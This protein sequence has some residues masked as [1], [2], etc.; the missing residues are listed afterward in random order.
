MLRPFPITNFKA[1]RL[2]IEPD[3]AGAQ[4]AIDMLN[5]ELDRPGAVRSRDGYAKLTTS[6][7]ATR[8]DSVAAVAVGTSTA[9]SLKSAGTGADDATVGSAA[10]TNPGNITSSDNAYATFT[11]AQSHYLKATNFGF[12][13]PASATITGILVEVETS[14]D[15]GTQAFLVSMKLV[16]GGVIQNAQDKQPDVWNNTTDAYRSYGGSSDTW[17]N[18]WTQTDINASTFGVVLSVSMLPF[19]GTV[20]VDHVRITVYYTAANTTYVVAGATAGRLDAINSDGTVAATVATAAD[21]QASYANVGSPSASATYIGVGSGST[22]RKFVAPTTFSTPAGMPKARFVALQSPDNRLVA[23]NINA[24]P[25]GAGSTASTS[26]VHFS[27][28]GAPETW[29]ANNFVYVSPGDGEDIQGICAWRELVIVWKSTKFFVFFGNATDGSGNPIFQYRSITGIGAALASPLGVAPSPN[30]VYFIDRRGIYL[31]TGQ[32][33]TRISNHVDPL[34]IGGASSFY[35]GGII[36]PT[37]LSQCSLCWFSG[38]LYMGFPSGSATTN[39][40]TLVLNPEN[41][42]WMLWDMPMGAICSVGSQPANLVFTYSQ[43]TFDLGQY[44]QNAYSTDAGAAINWRY[45]SGFY[46]AGNAPSQETTI[47][48]T[49]ADGVGSPTLSVSRDFGAVPSVGGG[50]Q[51]VVA[52]GTAPATKEGRHRNAQR[53]RRFSYQFEGATAARIDSL[54]HQ[55]RDARPSTEQTA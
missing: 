51:A 41:G 22:I 23:A 43:S 2:D 32:T 33:P 48:E 12:S 16:K 49:V 9:S 29:S 44:A 54:T 34:F 1:L 45:R 42:D 50:A 37:V 14:V 10:W 36:N 35:R 8:Y 3:E 13:L 24:I 39:D 40:K 31:T 4:Q 18:L 20:R 7:G 28:A 6:A 21:Q 26:L 15:A 5:C 30:G 27:D 11:G 46:T 19:T 25:T 38:R 47:R 52:M 17:A 53:G 55:I